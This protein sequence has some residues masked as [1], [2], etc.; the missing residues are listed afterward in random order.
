MPNPPRLTQPRKWRSL[1]IASASV[2]LAVAA[3]PSL[4]G[5]NGPAPITLAMPGRSA[6]AR[7]WPAGSQGGEGG[8]SGLVATVTNP[9]SAYLAELMIVEGHMIAALDL[10]S[11][12]QTDLA[13]ELASRPESG[14]MMATVRKAV[15]AHAAPDFTAATTAFTKALTDGAS[16]DDAR[17]AL[18]AVH[19]GV[20]AAAAGQ[21]SDLKTRLNAVVV[22]LKAA[23]DEYLGAFDA[24]KVVDVLAY[25]EAH[26]FVAIARSEAAI[27]I[28]EPLTAKA[29]SRA[30]DA[31]Q[32][33][34]Q[35]F[36]D[37]TKTTVEARDPA[38]LAAV[39]ARVELIASA[40]R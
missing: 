36:S 7:L 2:T 38:I 12:G 20:G 1:A 19:A 11:K 4:A 35:A 16:V 13:V 3:A 26:A 40:V 9:E 24:G 25:H 39:A 5:L 29:A 27:L 17:V 21:K 28:G 31:M 30:L 8:E 22:L 23:S 33:A 15:A 34:D 18:S 6:D 37:M 14:G 10:Y 32:A